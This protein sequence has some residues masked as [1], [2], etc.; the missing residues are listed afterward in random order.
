MLKDPFGQNVDAHHRRG[1]KGRDHLHPHP[2]LAGAGRALEHLPEVGS[3]LRRTG[4]IAPAGRTL[5]KQ[6]CRTAGTESGPG[7]LLIVG[8]C[9]GVIVI[10]LEAVFAKLVRQPDRDLLAAS[11]I[12]ESHRA[13]EALVLLAFRGLVLD[14]IAK[15]R[16]GREVGGISPVEILAAHAA[17]LDR[18]ALAPALRTGIHEFA[19]EAPAIGSSATIHPL[20]A[21]PEDV[22]LGPD[23]RLPMD[24][25][26]G[27]EQEI[28]LDLAA[29]VG[30]IGALPDRGSGELVAELFE[31][32]GLGQFLL[33]DA[34]ERIARKQ[35]AQE[36]SEMRAHLPPAM[37]RPRGLETGR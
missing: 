23:E 21:A 37:V 10:I 19:V 4:R 15:A 27:P 9:I 17:E 29:Q 26:A 22:H 20:K 25:R 24:P 2:V 16:I 3:R 34:Q 14:E 6:R 7:N 32:P 13:R 36:L 28:G 5:G 31:R 18:K 35:R 30:L 11:L 1:A 8:R 33:D 12:H